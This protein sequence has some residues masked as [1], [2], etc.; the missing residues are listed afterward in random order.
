VVSFLYSQGYLYFPSVSATFSTEPAL[1]LPSTHFEKILYDFIGDV[2][3]RIDIK[4]LATVDLVKLNATQVA[5]TYSVADVEKSSAEIVAITEDY[6][7]S[8]G[9][10]L[11]ASAFKKKSAQFKGVCTVVK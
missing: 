3:H 1:D 5:I 2:N 4:I 8:S 6:Q 11:A 9:L 7:K 10:D